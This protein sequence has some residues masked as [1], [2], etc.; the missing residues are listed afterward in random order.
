MSG[1]TPKSNRWFLILRIAILAALL[2]PATA[3]AAGRIRRPTVRIEI[4]DA[5]G[6][7]YGTGTIISSQFGRT[8]ILTCG[9]IFRKWSEKSE[10]TVDLFWK[11]KHE[12]GPISERYVGNL[13]DHTEKPD[14]G[15]VWIGT[16][17]KMYVS[18]VAKKG[19]VPKVGDK[20]YGVGCSEGKMPTTMWCHVTAV[21][22]YLGPAN[23][24][25]TG[26]PAQGRSGGGLFNEDGDLIG[27]CINADT[28]DK[29][30]I[31]VGLKPIHAILD[32]NGVVVR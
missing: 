2:S 12:R 31:Y 26:V 17:D 18:G 13:V 10:I 5:T 7:N 16:E 23:I 4:K 25:C 32:R 3:D 30:G 28:E 22:R 19:T 24:E 9:H 20:V 14:L 15:L 27:V 29:R 1:P 21:D 11:S 8:T 6:V